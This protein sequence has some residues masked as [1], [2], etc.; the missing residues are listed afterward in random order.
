MTNTQHHLICATGLCFSL[1]ACTP[2]PIAP[3]GGHDHP[4]DVSAL[5]ATLPVES[6]TLTNSPPVEA[7]EPIRM[8]HHGM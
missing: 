3:P 8:M 4:A 7:P 1:C 2:A 6:N 5:E